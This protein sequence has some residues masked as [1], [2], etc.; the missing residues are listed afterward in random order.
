MSQVYNLDIVGAFYGNMDV[1]FKVRQLYID[2]A[3]S[4][5][6]NNSFSITPINALFGKDPLPDSVKICTVAPFKPLPP[7]HIALTINYDGPALN[8][9][10]PT[11]TYAELTL[12]NAS[13]T[14]TVFNSQIV[15]S[16]ADALTAA[17]FAYV[18]TTA[19]TDPALA[20]WSPCHQLL[21]YALAK[22]EVDY[23]LAA[24]CDSSVLPLGLTPPSASRPTILAEAANGQILA[25]SLGTALGDLDAS[26]LYFEWVPVASLPTLD[27]AVLADLLDACAVSTFSILAQLRLVV[28]GDQT[29]LFRDGLAPHARAEAAWRW[30]SLTSDQRTKLN[31]TYRDASR[32]PRERKQRAAEPGPTD[33]HHRGLTLVK[34]LRTEW[35]RMVLVIRGERGVFHNT[36]MMRRDRMSQGR[37]ESVSLICDERDQLRMVLCRA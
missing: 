23:E 14:W 5:P 28:P 36:Y 10:A 31:R 25:A 1:A 2:A 27:A 16:A 35:T 7:E 37:L 19:S 8:P 20:V 13:T 9:F 18:P 33:I 4:N 12:L 34:A 21:G 17:V 26:K 11:Y 29:W 6:N 24:S 22:T 15:T 32:L 3:T 30:M